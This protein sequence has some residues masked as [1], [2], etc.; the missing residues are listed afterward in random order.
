LIKN[1]SA[2]EA[3]LFAPAL[4]DNLG[5]TAET[6]I[7]LTS[8]VNNEGGLFIEVRPID[9]SF[10][11]PVRFE[12]SLNA[13]QG[14]LGFD[15]TKKSVL[16]DSIGKRYIPLEWQGDKGGHHISGVLVF[17]SIPAQVNNMTLVISDVYGIKERIFKWNINE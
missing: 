2:R 17:P 11:N 15:L 16:I 1:G 7:S 13:H 4:H 12:I 5:I 9:F 6:A 8:R 10:G 14:D 3:A